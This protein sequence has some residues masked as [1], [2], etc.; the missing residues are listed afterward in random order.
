MKNLLNRYIHGTEKDRAEIVLTVKGLKRERRQAEDR[1]R[2]NPV[3]M[4]R[5]CVLLD[6]KQLG[7]E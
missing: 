4:L 3:D 5:V 2:K 7:G 1:I 6:I